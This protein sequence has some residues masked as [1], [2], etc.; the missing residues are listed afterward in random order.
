M[1]RIW[2][3]KALLASAFLPLLLYICQSVLME[4]KP[5]YPWVLLAMADLSCCLLSSMGVILAPLMA[6]CFLIVS[7]ITNRNI[8]HV[9]KTLLCFIPSVILGGIYIWIS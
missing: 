1:I 9:W 6:G 8:H 2:Q 5:E 3:G 4:K 7:L